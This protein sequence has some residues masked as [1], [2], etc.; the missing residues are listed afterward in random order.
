LGKIEEMI[1]KKLSCWKGKYLSVSGRLVLINS[2]LTSLSMFMLS[3]FEVLRGVLEKIG[4]FR[5]RF[6]WQHDSQKKKYRLTK[7]SIMC[8]PK[9][10]G[11]LGIQNL[12]IQNECLL[13]K[14]FFKLINED[15][16]WQTILRNK[17]LAN[18]TIGKVDRLPG[19]SHFWSGLMKVKDKFLRFGS[20][21]LNNRT[22]IRFWEDK[23]I[24]NHAFKDQYPS[25]YNIMR[26]KSD[27]VAKVLSGVPLNVSFRR[28]LTGN[29]L[30]LWH[31]LVNRIVGV[32]LNNNADLFRWNLH[33]HGKFSAH[34]MYLALINNGM[35]IRNNMIWRLK[36]P[37]K[38]K[39][40]IWY[41]YKEVVL[42]KD[43]LARRNWNGGKQCCFCHKTKTIK[44]LF[45]ECWYAKFIWGLSQIAFNII[46]PYRV[47]NMFGTWLNQFGG[48]LKR[49][50]LAGASVFC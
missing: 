27:T 33:Q 17:Y 40:F 7:W 49:Q 9:D 19:D 2:V 32:R 8:Q 21:Q 11:G 37:L 6:F 13:S 23:W 48:N 43:N 47:D 20:F 44:H 35:V 16:L 31:S 5:S 4:Y 22:Q 30:V 14:W 12:E 26:R 36:I 50:V 39:I 24:G 38:I 3:F 42:I 34:S 29:N 15:G 25:L 10:Q 18:Q 28:Q 45:F 41:M 46:P 1:E